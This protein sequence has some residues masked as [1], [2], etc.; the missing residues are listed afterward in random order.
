MTGNRRCSVL[1]VTT[2][3][4][5]MAQEVDHPEKAWQLAGEWAALLRSDLLATATFEVVQNTTLRDARPA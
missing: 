3:I 1:L 5:E 4:G 2:R